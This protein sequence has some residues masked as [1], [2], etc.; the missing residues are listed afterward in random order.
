MRPSNLLK[1]AT[2]IRQFLPELLGEKASEVDEQLANLLVRCQD[3][4]PLENQITSLLASHETTRQWMRDFLAPDAARTRNRGYS[5][6]PGIA[7][8][9]APKYVCPEGDYIW[10]CLDSNGPIPLCPTHHIPLVPAK[11]S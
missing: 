6:L 9:S 3:G 8:V 4:E 10:Y 5:S 2:S 1:A 11:N 7:S